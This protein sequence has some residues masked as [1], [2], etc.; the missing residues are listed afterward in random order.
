MAV[1]ETAALKAC[2]WGLGQ[3]LGENHLMVNFATVQEMVKAFMDDEETHLEAI[4]QFLISSGIDDDLRA[5]NWAVVAR[6]YNGPGYAKNKYD[7][8]MRDAF[9]KWQEI[10]DTPWSPDDLQVEP[11]PATPA[12]PVEDQPAKPSAWASLISALI[13]LF[14]RSAK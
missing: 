10:R 12:A 3:V 4:V 14:K 1:D 8:K 13:G 6:V 7:T 9:A 11:A 5:H 2:S